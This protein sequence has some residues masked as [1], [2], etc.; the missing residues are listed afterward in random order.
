MFFVVIFMRILKP[1][2]RSV[3]SPCVVFF[4]IS[5]YCSLVVFMFFDHIA[6]HTYATINI[7]IKGQEK[8]DQ[9]SPKSLN[10]EL[11]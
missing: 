4:A 9:L 10:I 7:V 6:Y 5:T 11:N 3:S 2:A 8:T 1:I